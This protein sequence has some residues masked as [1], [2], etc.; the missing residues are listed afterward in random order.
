MKTKN[1][2]FLGLLGAAGISSMA[3]APSAEA[4]VL[5]LGFNNATF[6]GG[7]GLSG[8][9]SFNTSNLTYSNISITST[10][11]D[12]GNVATSGFSNPFTYSSSNSSILSQSGTSLVLRSPNSGNPAR[13]LTLIFQTSLATLAN[14]GDSTSLVIYDAEA[15]PVTGSREAFFPS[16]GQSTTAGISGGTVVVTPVPFESDAFPVV[17]SGVLLGAGFWLK[18]KR[19][20]AKVQL[21][22]SLPQPPEMVA[23]AAE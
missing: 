5:N 12:I 14:V 8:S 17:A 6:V 3:F 10:S 21:P 15:D 1:L 13:R 9:F 4:V 20:M 16:V 19:D 23:S 18:R 11:S 2:A 22:V 7:G